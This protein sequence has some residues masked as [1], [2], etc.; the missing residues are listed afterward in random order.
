MSV[1]TD[2][3][4][5]R[6][7]VTGRCRQAARLGLATSISCPSVRPHHQISRE[8][9]VARSAFIGAGSDLGARQGRGVL[10]SA[11]RFPAGAL[12]ASTTRNPLGR[13]AWRV[14]RRSVVDLC[15]RQPISVG[16]NPRMSTRSPGTARNH[17]HVA[18]PR[19]AQEARCR[20]QYWIR[21]WCVESWVDRGYRGRKE[22]RVVAA[23]GT[24]GGGDRLRC[25][26][27]G[28]C[29]AGHRWAG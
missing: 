7:R 18:Y 9:L 11:G 3:K 2:R 13:L 16:R 23:R 24:R 14:S 4:W 5:S 22:R 6:D 1:P 12:R 27:A 19:T 29:C 8:S 10:A 20:A 25:A 15:P 17:P 21:C 28:S 26:G